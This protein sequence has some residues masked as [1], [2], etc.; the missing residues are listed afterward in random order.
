MKVANQTGFRGVVGATHQ[1]VY[2]ALF[3]KVQIL[4]TLNSRTRGFI[5][6]IGGEK[7]G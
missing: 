6:F 3:C 2:V 5:V 7:G 4:A 1:K